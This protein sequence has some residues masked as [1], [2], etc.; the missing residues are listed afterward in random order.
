[1]WNLE[2]NNHYEEATKEVAHQSLA[3]GIDPNNVSPE[4]AAELEAI[5][6]STQEDL[7]DFAW[8]MYASLC[9]R[10]TNPDLRC[11]DILWVMK[12]NLWIS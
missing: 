6:Y 8:E 9:W 4:F 7:K 11:R 1:M 10:P 2:N 5:R 12:W 3:E